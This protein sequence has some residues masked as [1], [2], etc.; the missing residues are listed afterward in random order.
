MTAAPPEV[1]PALLEQLAPDGQL[2]I[3]VG[4]WDQELRIYEREEGE[5]KVRSVFPVR[6]VPMRGGEADP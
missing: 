4:D 3:P 2:V 6:F 1:P 5:T